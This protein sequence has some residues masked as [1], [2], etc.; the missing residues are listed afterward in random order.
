MRVISSSDREDGL[1]HD[2]PKYHSRVDSHGNAV[3]YRDHAD[4]DGDGDF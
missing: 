2:L 4:L 3:V 1:P